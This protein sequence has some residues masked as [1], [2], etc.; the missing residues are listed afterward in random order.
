[1]LS[2]LPV[3]LATGWRLSARLAR[4]YYVRLDAN[5]YSVHPAVI[6][7]LIEV[8]A[9]LSTVRVLYGGQVVADQRHR[10]PAPAS[11]GCAPAS[12]RIR[13]QSCSLG[14]HGS[15]VS[16]GTRPRCV[17]PARPAGRPPGC[18]GP[19]PPGWTRAALPHQEVVEQPDRHHSVESEVVSSRP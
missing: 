12:S 2:L 15:L 7:R 1:M 14:I 6:G 11:G 4:D 16:R 13:S 19:A 17:P 10:R 9:D 8:T 18:N 3:A 5:N